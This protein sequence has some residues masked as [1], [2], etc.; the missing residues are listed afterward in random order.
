MRPEHALD[1]PFEGLVVEVVE[2][3][4]GVTRPDLVRWLRDDFIPQRLAGSPVAQCLGFSPDPP[5]EL[6][7]EITRS[8]AA[9]LG[10]TPSLPSVPDHDRLL[11][12][13]WFLQVDPRQ[14]WPHFARHGKM[15]ELSG[16]GRLLFAAPFVPT[17]P[18]TELF[19]DELRGD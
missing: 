11:T 14:H 15:I 8:I 17:V 3:A 19:V 18:G 16:V 7:T 1:H 12:L 9:E 2:P 5:T 4:V 13:L 6:A 10:V